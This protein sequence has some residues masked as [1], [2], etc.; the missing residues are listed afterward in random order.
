[1]INNND[2]IQE[3]FENEKNDI[4]SFQLIKQSLVFFNFDGV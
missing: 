1:M 3:E 4:F 2:K